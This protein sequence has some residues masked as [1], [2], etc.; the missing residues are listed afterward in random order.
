MHV[1]GEE[2]NGKG[3]RLEGVYVGTVL[4]EDASIKIMGSVRTYAETR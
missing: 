1:C 4:V 2:S 3:V